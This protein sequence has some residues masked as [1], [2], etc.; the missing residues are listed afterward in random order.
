MHWFEYHGID[1]PDGVQLPDDARAYCP[2]P[3]YVVAIN[4]TVANVTAV[5]PHWPHLLAGLDAEATQPLPKEAVV[6]L[7]VTCGNATHTSNSTS[8]RPRPGELAKVPVSMYA[9]APGLAPVAALPPSGAAAQSRQ[10]MLPLGPGQR[11]SSH[12]HRSVNGSLT[13]DMS[14]NRTTTVSAWGPGIQIVGFS[15][16]ASVAGTWGWV[17][18]VSYPEP[19]GLVSGSNNVEWYYGD[20]NINEN[21]AQDV[22]WL[23]V[24]PPN[25]R[26]I[27]VEARL[28][29][30][31]QPWPAFARLRGLCSATK[32]RIPKAMLSH[33]DSFQ[34][35][36]P[37][38]HHCLFAE[39]CFGVGVFLNGHQVAD[40]EGCMLR[41][42]YMAAGAVLGL[43]WGCGCIIKDCYTS[44]VAETV[45]GAAPRLLPLCCRPACCAVK[46]PK[47]LLHLRWRAAAAGKAAA[48]AGVM[49][50]CGATLSGQTAA[51]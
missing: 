21:L 27:A 51:S 19:H 4:V 38:C 13:L 17:S 23:D 36:V 30:P 2:P 6:R 1:A 12:T 3:Q 49:L 9:G 33:A 44:Q 18:N 20:Y 26:V 42:A 32:L 31:A 5:P 47:L 15:R 22:T 43:S 45:L 10:G 40:D 50:R 16:I 37:V 14:T 7:D 46:F 11:T 28:P 48:A 8:L 35:A 24:C 34:R 39:R 41:Q 29:S 25:T